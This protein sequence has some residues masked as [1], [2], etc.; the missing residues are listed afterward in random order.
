MELKHQST[1]TSTNTSASFTRT[2]MEL[3]LFIS[4]SSI[5][6]DRVLLVPL[7][8]WNESSGHYP[9]HLLQFYSYLYGIETK[10]IHALSLLRVGFYSY[11]YGIETREAAL[12]FCL[13]RMFY[14]YLY[15]TEIQ[16][17]GMKNA[18]HETLVKFIH[19]AR[20]KLELWVYSVQSYAR[21]RGTSIVPC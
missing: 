16:I 2:F 9:L 6:T 20:G 18:Y 19:F 15:G 21:K 4:H 7:W 11:L 10:K 14:S 3:K 13:W 5:L 12:Q 1:N 8:N 17:D